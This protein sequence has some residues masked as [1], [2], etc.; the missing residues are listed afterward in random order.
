M[1]W[2]QGV[3]AWVDVKGARSA[4]PMAQNNDVKVEVQNEMNDPDLM[5]DLK[6]AGVVPGGTVEVEALGGA[7][8]IQVRGGNGTTAELDP[9]VAHAV[10]VL[11]R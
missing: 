10:M 5:A 4:V 3:G 9:A 6:A 2:Q 8:V 1:R 11:A 7:K